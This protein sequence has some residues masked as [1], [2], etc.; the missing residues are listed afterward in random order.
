MDVEINKCMLI[1]ESI[2]TQVTSVL[3]DIL[4]ITWSNPFIS[5]MRRTENEAHRAI[6]FT[7]SRKKE[8]KQFYQISNSILQPTGTKSHVS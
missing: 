5:Q 6:S 4:K 3:K 2:S 1:T 7:F 8:K